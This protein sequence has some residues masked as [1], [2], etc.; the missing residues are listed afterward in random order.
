MN[1]IYKYIGVAAM[2]IT[3]LSSCDLDS[4]S[5][6]EKD[7]SNFPTTKD[8]CQQAL[9]GVYAN[10]N[11]YSDS[12]QFT[13]LFNSLLAS[14]DMLGGG[15]GNDQS[16][17]A[18]DMLKNYG[19]DMT[20]S[21]FLQRYQGINRA[22]TL[23]EA[24]D[25]VS[26]NE[27]DK[28]DTKGQLLFLRAF[29]YYE[30]AS[31]YNKVPLV[32]TAKV[33][34]DLIPPSAAKLWGQILLDLKQACDLLPA[35]NNHNNGNVD[36]YCAEA[37]LGRA[38]LYYTGMYC[39]GEDIKD[40]T[41]TNYK[42][43][44]S[45]TLADGSTLTKQNVISYIDDCVNNSGYSLVTDYRS[46]W[47]YSNKYTVNDFYK[48]KGSGITWCQDDENGSINAADTENMFAIKFNKLAAWSNAAGGNNIGYCNYYCTFFGLRGDQDVANTFP[49]GQGWGAGPVAP[50]LVQDWESASPKD[51]KGNVKDIRLNASV[52]IL[53][54]LPNY[55]K[56]GG[57]WKDYKQE[58]DYANMKL[59]PVCCK[60]DDK[61][62]GGY[63]KVFEYAMY[64]TD[65]WLNADAKTSNIHDLVMIRF[66]DVLL[67]QAELKEEV[68]SGL[69]AIMKRAGYSDADIPGTYSLDL[70]K[71]QRR[72]ELAFEGTRW[73]DIR[74]WHIAAAALDRQNGCKIYTDGTEDTNVSGY[75]ARYEETAGFQK[76]PET[77]ITNSN[78]Q[79]TQNP[80]FTDANSNY[81]GWGA[82]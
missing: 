34:D 8:D 53:A 40:L 74:R 36:K 80:G 43:L 19:T 62:Q 81:T 54:D 10:L 58:T 32:L 77:E 3:C 49:F 71:N 69:R 16:T 31:M 66:A 27:D 25:N 51:D 73:N 22:N 37:M 65:G 21:F 72:F 11:G 60:T 55:Q 61:G 59:G 12:P 14:D 2:A 33:P 5:M 67:M 48:T 70:I 41:S 42:P 9:A 29:N 18:Q 45:V 57:G 44:E 35:K 23:L 68:T 50:N 47:A 13:F 75:G 20:K 46:L 1:K 82:K 38:W 76:I 7:T 24:L 52:Q 64:G 17:Q 28:N 63:Y 26:M 6:T 4:M 30:L 15:G 78:N 56:A 39:N 79:M